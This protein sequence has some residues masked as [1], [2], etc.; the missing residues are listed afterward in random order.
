[1]SDSPERLALEMFV[2]GTHK[3][4]R[5]SDPSAARWFCQSLTIFNSDLGQVDFFFLYLIVPA[6]RVD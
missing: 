4:E 2:E 1:M 6:C 5:V 3:A